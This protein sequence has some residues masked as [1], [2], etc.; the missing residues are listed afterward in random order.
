MIIR[1]Q[2][3]LIGISEFARAIGRSKTHVSRCFRGERDLAPLKALARQK[4]IAW[5]RISRVKR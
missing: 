2:E 4:G 3:R 5:P 1:S